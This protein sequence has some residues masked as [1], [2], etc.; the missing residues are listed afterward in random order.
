MLPSAPRPQ[1]PPAPQAAQQP[2]SL[3][4]VPQR[5][6]AI[7]DGMLERVTF[8][9]PE[10]GGRDDGRVT[11][12]RARSLLRHEPTPAQRSII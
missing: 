1:T 10:S 11:K 5:D 3:Q 12:L 8:S 2:A 4:Q 6:I 7:L 9:N